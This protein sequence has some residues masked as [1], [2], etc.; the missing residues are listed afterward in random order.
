M[1]FYDR[2]RELSWLQSTREIAFNNHSQM[3]MV[4]GRR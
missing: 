2:K 4:T 1:K 3:T